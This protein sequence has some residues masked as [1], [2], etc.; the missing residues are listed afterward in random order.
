MYLAISIYI[1][2]LLAL[3]AVPMVFAERFG[4]KGLFF[5]VA[6]ALA[7]VFAGGSIWL[8]LVPF[9]TGPMRDVE[10]PAFALIWQFWPALAICL[11]GVVSA[12]ILPSIRRHSR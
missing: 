2:A 5:S 6:S 12:A 3:A 10:G 1:S 7:L 11:G 9:E 8:A 4:W